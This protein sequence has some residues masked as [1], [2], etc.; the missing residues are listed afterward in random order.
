MLIVGV[1]IPRY[2]NFQQTRLPANV[3]VA[4]PEPARI[5][6]TQAPV[7]VALNVRTS[8]AC[9]ANDVFDVA[10]GTGGVWVS[11][12]GAPEVA[13]VDPATDRIVGRI[14]FPPGT[15]PHG[16]AVTPAMVS[17]SVADPADDT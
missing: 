1:P 10:A 15:E 5:P 4:V 14:E 2:V 6:W 3:S 13:H 7:S 11:N 17:V 12:R 9:V 16:V 8:S